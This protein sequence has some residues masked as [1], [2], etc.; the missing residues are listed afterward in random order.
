MPVN[1]DKNVDEHVNKLHL[2]I[3]LPLLSGHSVSFITITILQ[4][5]PQV[6]QHCLHQIRSTLQVCLHCYILFTM[7]PTLKQPVN[8]LSGCQVNSRQ[9]SHCLLLNFLY[10]CQ[11]CQHHVPV[12]TV[13][14]NL[15][16]I[17]E[18]GRTR[19]FITPLKLQHMTSVVTQH[20]MVTKLSITY[21]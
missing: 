5:I 21:L 7:C 13:F 14:R 19:T 4:L 16:L 17:F 2:K 10:S 9:A 15:F 20:I 6:L 11:C 3:Q 12:G 1:W 8:L 18:R